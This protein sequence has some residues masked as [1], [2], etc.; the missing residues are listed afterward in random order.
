MEPHAAFL[1]MLHDS[2]AN[3]L[4]VVAATP[5]AAK[6]SAR[7]KKGALWNGASK[8]TL[9]M[10]AFQVLREAKPILRSPHGT[11][12]AARTLVPLKV[13]A[14][15]GGEVASGRWRGGEK[16]EWELRAGS[17]EQGAAG[18]QS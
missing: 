8:N 9:S 17:C 11:D 15:G 10:E 1:L 18:R 2:N 5:E 6:Q 16:V 14:D 12:P 3:E 7:A 13:R 4:S